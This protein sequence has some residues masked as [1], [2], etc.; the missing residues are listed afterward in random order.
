MEEVADEISKWKF[1]LMGNVLGAKPT[2]KTITEFVQKHWN[3]GPLSLVQYFK[4]G[5][6]SF[7]FDC[8][9]DMN[10][11]LKRG[12]W[13]LGP[14]SLVLKQWSPY[15]SCIMECVS[16]VPVWILFPDLDPYM[17]I[18][19][20]LSKMASKIGKPL[21]PD[22]HTTCQARLSF[23]RVM[24]EV[25]VAKKLPEDVVINAPFIRNSVQRIIYE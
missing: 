4:K 3:H 8:E 11:V 22:L 23:A 6:F 10:E 17:W 19:S 12:P 7:K 24:V 25:D 5:W 18:D 1:T 14:N 20:I 15:F 9:E 21:F 13:T 16:T 2:L